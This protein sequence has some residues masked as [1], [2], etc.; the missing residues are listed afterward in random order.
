[1]IHTKE[2]RFGN[3]VKTLAGQTITVQQLHASS[4]IFES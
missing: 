3:K 1:M 4:V 2:L